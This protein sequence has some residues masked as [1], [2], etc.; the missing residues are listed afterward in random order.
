MTKEAGNCLL[1][2][3]EEPPKFTTIIMTGSNEGMFLNTIKSRCMKIIFHK[4]QD[5]VLYNFLKEKEGITL[6]PKLLKACEGSIEKAINV[7]K[8]KE[9]YEKVSQIFSKIE[10]FKL[11]DVVN[12]LDFLYD[13]EN[14]FE[15]LDY[16]NIIMSEKITQN[17]KYIEYIKV[18]E[19]TKKR[20]QQNSNYDM[21]I[22]NM[23]FKIW[24]E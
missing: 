22:D 6:E 7:N 10:D 21:T 23:L 14:I 11:L 12:K 2:T 18:I 17:L 8:N 1:K 4:I 20:L 15:L 24:E 16:I 13:K 19:E 3:L 9:Q 5:D